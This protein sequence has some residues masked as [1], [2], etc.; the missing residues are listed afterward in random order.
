MFEKT[1]KNIFTS[2]L[3][4]KIVSIKG[5]VVILLF[6]ILSNSCT[7]IDNA[8]ANL[9]EMRK[10]HNT[11]GWN[12]VPDKNLVTENLDSI[13]VSFLELVETI[14]LDPENKKAIN[15]YQDKILSHV[16]DASAVKI[17]MINDELLDIITKINTKIGV[18]NLVIK[19]PEIKISFNANEYQ[20]YTILGQEY[21]CLVSKII[22]SY[23]EYYD[24]LLTS[25]HIS[26][27]YTELSQLYSGLVDKDKKIFREN[28]Q[29]VIKLKDDIEIL[30]IFVEGIEIETF[31]LS[32]LTKNENKYEKNFRIKRLNRI[33]YTKLFSYFKF[34]EMLNKDSF[35]P[36]K[37]IDI[38]KDK[39]LDIE[40]KQKLF[41]DFIVS[42][43]TKGY[44]N[45]QTNNLSN[46][47][48]LDIRLSEGYVT[49]WSQELKL[50]IFL[51]ILFNLK[52]MWI[53]NIILDKDYNPV[54][55]W[56]TQWSMFDDNLWP[57]AFK[58]FYVKN[59]MYIHI[60]NISD[61]PD[62]LWKKIILTKDLNDF[63]IFFVSIK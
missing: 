51:Q 7:D 34:K 30:H 52:G 61:M 57:W 32:G 38:F 15:L 3:I 43:R 5:F 60:K 55:D 22:D 48:N 35:E 42:Y 58:L 37:L 13:W 36:R 63:Y 23:K 44:F 8:E 33:I 50:N 56:Y 26:L 4:H 29:F 16:D 40:L 45:L 49:F 11:N 27:L 2:F 41:N 31:T 14:I 12:N 54:E 62:Y 21:I 10:Q 19:Y 24:K 1:H 46:V 47:V 20:S 28:I 17:R 59:W 39:W 25:T 18:P 53:S 6:T 9:N